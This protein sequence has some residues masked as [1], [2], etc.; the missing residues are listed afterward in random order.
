VRELRY[1]SVPGPF[2][3]E[4]IFLGGEVGSFGG[5]AESL[6]FPMPVCSAE[7]LDDQPGEVV[8][9]HMRREF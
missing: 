1:F 2:E 8:D 9:R 7:N 3:D 5:G 6:V 4:E